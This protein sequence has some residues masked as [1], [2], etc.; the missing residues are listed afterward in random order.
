MT[1]P[2]Q[3]MDHHELFPRSQIKAGVINH[4]GAKQWFAVDSVKW[5]KKEKKRSQA[6]NWAVTVYCSL[7]TRRENQSSYIWKKT[8]DADGEVSW[9]SVSQACACCA[10][11]TRATVFLKTVR[12]LKS[13]NTF[14]TRSSAA[15]QYLDDAQSCEGQKRQTGFRNIWEVVVWKRGRHSID[16][17]R[18]R[19]HHQTLSEARQQKSDIV[20]PTE[21]S[22]QSC[23]WNKL[24]DSDRTDASEPLV[25]ETTAVAA[26]SSLLDSNWFNRLCVWLT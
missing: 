18:E 6:R 15:T 2:Q 12:L 14:F 16:T 10:R 25:S 7:E 22:L 3:K 20:F 13:H 1:A 5:K 9:Y 11:L 4:F 26:S 23:G 19:Y 21:K 8:A 17:V 24:S